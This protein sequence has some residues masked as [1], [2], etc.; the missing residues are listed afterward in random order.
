LNFLGIGSIKLI[1]FDFSFAIFGRIDLE[2][3][4]WFDT[5]PCFEVFSKATAS[6]DDFVE[7]GA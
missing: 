7:A 3:Q 5:F 2:L 6:L 1:W 4:M